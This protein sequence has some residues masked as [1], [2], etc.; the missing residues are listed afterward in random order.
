MDWPLHVP[1][2]MVPLVTV[3]SQDPAT[4]EAEAPPEELEE[5]LFL[6]ATNS[7]A[8]IPAQTANAVHRFMLSF[9]GTNKVRT[10]CNIVARLV[11]ER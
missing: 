6:H 4:L 5:E 11:K 1:E 9:L 2:V 7:S 8:D 10:T 3:P